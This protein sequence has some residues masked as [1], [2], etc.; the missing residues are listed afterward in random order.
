MKNLKNW[1]KEIIKKIAFYKK[2]K[3]MDFFAAYMGWNSWSLPPSYYYRYTLEEL[4]EI[5]RELREKVQVYFD[6][7]EKEE[8]AEKKGTSDMQE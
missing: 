7:W 1:I 5:K 8:Q 6:E 2:M 3:E 4:E